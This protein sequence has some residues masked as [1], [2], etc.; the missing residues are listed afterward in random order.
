MI[1]KLLVI[2]VLLSAASY[3]L[4]KGVEKVLTMRRKMRNKK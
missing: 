2:V 1:T 3:I 4:L